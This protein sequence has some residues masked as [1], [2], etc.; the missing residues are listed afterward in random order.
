MP[1]EQPP[2]ALDRVGHMEQPADQGLDPR[3]RPPLVRPPVNE[4]PAPQLPLQ[5]SDLGLTE[6]GAAR[7][8]LRQDPGFA[9]FTPG[10]APPLHRPLTHPQLG[11]DLPVLRPG[12]EAFHGPQPYPLPRGPPDVGQPTA[13]R[14][15][16]ASRLPEPRNRHQ[17]NGTDITQSSS[18]VRVVRDNL[19][20]A[21]AERDDGSS[22]RS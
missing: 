15:P 18:V 17:A 3:Q 10:P 13:L 6:P 22:R 8:P 20:A 21:L 11:C 4:W 19:A 12:L 9:P 5:P 16:H 2:G 7:R 14:I 1:L